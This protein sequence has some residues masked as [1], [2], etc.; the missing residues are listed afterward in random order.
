MF[1]SW[2]R[3]ALFR[4]SSRADSYSCRAAASWVSP[5]WSWVRPIST[6]SCPRP[7]WASVPLRRSCTAVS[8]R[9]RSTGFSSSCRRT[10]C[11]SAS[12]E[13]RAESIFS[14]FSIWAFSWAMVSLRLCRRSLVASFKTFSVSSRVFTRRAALFSAPRAAE[15]VAR[16]SAQALRRSWRFLRPSRSV[17]RAASSA[18]AAVIAARRVSCSSGAASAK[19]CSRTAISA[20][21]ARICPSRAVTRAV[22]SARAASRVLPS[23]SVSAAFRMA[24]SA[25]PMEASMASRLAVS[26]SASFRFWGM[27]EERYWGS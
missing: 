18:L 13:R 20:S 19:R 22:T 21:L 4:A 14:P 11:S 9:P 3:L 12:W 2:S 7:I 24:S 5:A 23:A 26:P 16:S 6:R 15:R 27:A 1:R 10:V 8:A 25:R 17:W